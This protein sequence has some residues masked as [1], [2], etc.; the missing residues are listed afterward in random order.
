MLAHLGHWIYRNLGH[1]INSNLGHWI[2]S[3]ACF[4]TRP[5]DL[6]FSALAGQPQTPVLS[7]LEKKQNVPA[8]VLSL[9][10]LRGP[11]SHLIWNSL[12]NPPR[13]QKLPLLLLCYYYHTTGYT[14]SPSLGVSVGDFFSH[15]RFA[16]HCHVCLN[17]T[18]NVLIILQTVLIISVKDTKPK[19]H[20]R[21]Y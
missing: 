6:Q 12:C 14:A 17:S 10:I 7:S 2:Y 21:P 15:N 1:W 11:V 19:K 4:P 9:L 18:N 5:L 8:A 3:P 16:R 20:H 13:L